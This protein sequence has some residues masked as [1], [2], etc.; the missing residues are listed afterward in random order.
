MIDPPQSSMASFVERAHLPSTFLQPA[1]I[2][3]MIL[4]AAGQSPKEA[5]PHPQLKY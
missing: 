3:N 4:E 5:V 2:A 1:I